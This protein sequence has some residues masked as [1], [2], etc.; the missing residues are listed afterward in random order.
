MRHGTSKFIFGLLAVGLPGPAVAFSARWL[1]TAELCD[2]CPQWPGRRPSSRGLLCCTAYSEYRFLYSF[3]RNFPWCRDVLEHL[4]GH[5][6]H[7]EATM[8]IN[9]QEWGIL[10]VRVIASSTKSARRSEHVHVAKGTML[11]DRLHNP[12]IAPSAY[13]LRPGPCHPARKS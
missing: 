8:E 4:R 5:V 9:H 3:H 12:R 11:G 2:R 6:L 10:P 7:F 1:T 13:H